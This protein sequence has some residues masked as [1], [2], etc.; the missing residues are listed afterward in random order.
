MRYCFRTLKED[1]DINEA[2][3]KLEGK[4]RAEFIRNALRTYIQTQNI[5][6]ELAE[7]K[8]SIQE[9]KEILQQKNPRTQDFSVQPEPKNDSEPLAE[10]LFNNIIN[11]FLNM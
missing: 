10:E 6:A 5:V 8:K 2:L 7:I 9:I 3:Q 1:T 11:Q 4:A